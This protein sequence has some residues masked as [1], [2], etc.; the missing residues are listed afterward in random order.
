MNY[1]NPVVATIAVFVSW[2]VLDY[3]IHSMILMELYEQTAS[4]WR[5]M[6]EMKMGMMVG[7]VLLSALVYVL[8]YSLLI[9]DKTLKKRA[10]VRLVV[11]YRY[12]GLHG[13]RHLFG[14]T[15]SLFT[16]SRLVDR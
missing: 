10:P 15:D 3:I 4:L 12:R 5:P 2:E 7:T 11:W 8:I 14:T 9:K 6:E 1:R 13:L 16:R